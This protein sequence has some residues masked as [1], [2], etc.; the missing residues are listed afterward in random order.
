M[1][2]RA[3]HKPEPC[4]DFYSARVRLHEA[5]YCREQSDLLKNYEP[6]QFKEDVWGLAEVLKAA[7]AGENTGHAEP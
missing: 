4:Q 6:R 5:T 7:D 2:S 3:G 1:K